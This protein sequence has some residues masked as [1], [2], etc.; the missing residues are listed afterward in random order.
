[1]LRILL[2]SDL[3]GAM[4]LLPDF[5]REN[6]DVVIIAGDVTNGT[7]VE[8]RIDAF[9]QKLEFLGEFYFFQG[10]SDYPILVE[11]PLSNPKAKVLHKKVIRVGNYEILGAG[12]RRGRER[13]G[14]DRRGNEGRLLQSTD[15]ERI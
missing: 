1:M 4:P 12:E 15:E 13:R 6:F 9:V 2:L 14:G 10:N 11:M 8:S 7:K 5:K 3:H